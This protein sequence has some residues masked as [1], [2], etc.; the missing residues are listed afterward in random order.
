MFVLCIIWGQNIR[1]ST[2]FRL[3]T[4]PLR[5]AMWLICGFYSQTQP[6]CHV[7]TGPCSHGEN[8]DFYGFF[9]E[10]LLVF[11]HTRRPF[12]GRKRPISERIKSVHIVLSPSVCK[13]T[14]RVPQKTLKRSSLSF[15]VGE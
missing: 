13:K 8:F 12:P 15:W 11:L 1:K 14:N 7:T 5:C 9:G 10:T 4:N 6:Q 3:C 2:N